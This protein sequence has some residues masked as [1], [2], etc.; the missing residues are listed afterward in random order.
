MGLMGL[1]RN[2]REL[3]LQALFQV[4]FSDN[5][6]E[7]P[8]SFWTENKAQPVVRAYTEMLVAGVLQHLAE[9][10]A[11]IEKY[12]ENWSPERMALTDRNILRSSVFELL[13]KSIPP[14]VIINEAVD[15]AKKYGNED[16]GAFVNGILDHIHHDYLPTGTDGPIGD[17][18][19]ESISLTEN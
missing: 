9:I 7:A 17:R 13:Y 15:I 1:R 8:S 18:G 10:D 11:I 5:K 16:S 2:A 14:K 12:T 19:C 6:K 3:A 4:S